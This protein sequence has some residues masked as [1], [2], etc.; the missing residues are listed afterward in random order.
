MNGKIIAQNSCMDFNAMS[1]KR[2][3]AQHWHAII[4]HLDTF[5]LVIFKFMF[6]NMYCPVTRTTS[7][8]IK[9]ML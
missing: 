5:L 3:S 8:L 2:P 4:F 1:S 7:W 6:L 9:F